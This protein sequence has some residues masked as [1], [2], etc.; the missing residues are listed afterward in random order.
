[1]LSESVQPT[2][3][4]ASCG[5]GN[6]ED[7]GERRSIGDAVTALCSLYPPFVRSA[8]ITEG[9][10]RRYT[11]SFGVDVATPPLFQRLPLRDAI[12][13]CVPLRTCA[14]SPGPDGC[15]QARMRSHLLLSPP[16]LPSPSPLV[17]GPEKASRAHFCADALADAAAGATRRDDGHGP[18]SL[19]LVGVFG[20][21]RKEKV[22]TR[23][24]LSARV[25]LRGRIV[26]LSCDQ[27]QG[28]RRP[29]RRRIEN[30]SAAE[31]QRR[32][33]RGDAC[34]RGADGGGGVRLRS[35]YALARYRGCRENVPPL[36]EAEEPNHVLTTERQCGE[37][38]HG[39][40]SLQRNTEISLPRYH[41]C[42][43]AAALGDSGKRFWRECWR[44]CAAANQ[45]QRMANEY[46]HFRHCD[47]S[48]V[49]AMARV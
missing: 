43:I 28:H 44:T 34:C 2:V 38:F 48:M 24:F 10:H 23:V 36:W 15:R 17:P 37:V 22:D 12:R 5:F 42:T 18:P 8:V 40:L 32:C 39:L 29:E 41:V 47:E 1:M 13:V 3:Y 25:R 49:N 27:E 11:R 26:P 21:Q 14:T 20:P 16:P 31:R 35:R 19:P 30:P 7:E 45:G 4:H 33:R 9:L 46:E 6:A